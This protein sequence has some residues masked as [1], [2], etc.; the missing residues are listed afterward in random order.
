MLEA[1]HQSANGTP[2]HRRRPIGA[3]AFLWAAPAGGVRPM[4]P[5]SSPHNN[6]A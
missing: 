5:Q 4:T 6:V 1:G 3:V 2:Y